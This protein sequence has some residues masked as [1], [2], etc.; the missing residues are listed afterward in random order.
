[1]ERFSYGTI[2]EWFC[3][4]IFCNFSVKRINISVTDKSFQIVERILKSNKTE[5]PFRFTFG[6]NN[7]EMIP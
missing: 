3:N 5:K 6:T 7:L 1:M 2:L 4:V